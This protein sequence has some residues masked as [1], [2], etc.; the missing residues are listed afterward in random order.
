V[1]LIA[2]PEL[3]YRVEFLIVG[4]EPLIPIA[5]SL[6]LELPKQDELH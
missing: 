4:E 1:T 6:S 3:W 5:P 2:Y